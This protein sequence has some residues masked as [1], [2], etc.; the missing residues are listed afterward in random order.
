M[1]VTQGERSEE[2]AGMSKGIT[3]A[4]STGQEATEAGFLDTHFEACRPAYE[5]MVRSVGIRSGWRVLDAACG[6]GSFLPLLAELVGPGGSLAAFDLAP[7]NVAHAQRL[8]A[9]WAGTCP[10]EVRQASL[11]ALPYAD[12][13]FDAVWC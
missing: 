13:T 10:V 3:L 6:S 9:G 5:A 4:S 11:I 2:M 1:V 12:D 7:D 8:V